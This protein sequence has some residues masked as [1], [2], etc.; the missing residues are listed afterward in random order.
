MK[1]ID[2]PVVFADELLDDG[3]GAEFP[4]ED[5]PRVGFH[6]EMGA[7]AGLFCEEIEE[8]EEMWRGGLA[9]SEGGG[10]ERNVEMDAPFGGV[11]S[12]E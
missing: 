11:M 12:G 3:L 4:G 5:F 9:V 7:E 8:A 1:F 2:A 6:F 10:V